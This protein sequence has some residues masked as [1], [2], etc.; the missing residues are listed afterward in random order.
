MNRDFKGVWIPAFIW[1][2]TGLSAI[3]KVLLAE[4]DSF[5][6][7]DQAYYKS[8]ETIATE[9]GCSVSSVKRAVT[10]LSEMGYVE[11]VAFDG[12]RRALRSKIDPA[13][14]SESTGSRLKWS[15]QAGQNEPADRP[16]RTP[17]NTK[18]RTKKE[19]IKELA[20]PWVD[21]EETWHTWRN[22]K[23]DEHNFKFKSAQS[24]QAAIHNL[25]KISND[26]AETARAIIEQS[27]VN[28]W[29]G[30]F[31]LKGNGATR[32]AAGPQDRDKFAAYIR[33]GSI[34]TNP[35]GGME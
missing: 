30:L 8:N 33:T 11:R 22:Y 28:G 4:V 24:E 35:S 5:T 34:D 25:Q 23:R 18:K 16:K 14:R 1:L 17:S 3:E 31:A 13:V 10:K 2:D 26:N 29:K 27:I 15:G 12:R 21:F 32:N 19:H 7:R 9:L 20:M 6:S